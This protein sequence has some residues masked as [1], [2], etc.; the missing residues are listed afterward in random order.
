MN[1]DDRQQAKRIESRT[2]DRTGVPADHFA[3]APQPRSRRQLRK[4]RRAVKAA[5]RQRDAR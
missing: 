1:W 4:V 2:K 5:M 3:T